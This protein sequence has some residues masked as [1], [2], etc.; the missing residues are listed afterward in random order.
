MFIYISIYI[1]FLIGSLS[2]KTS[3]GGN[4]EHYAPTPTQT[5]RTPHTQRIPHTTRYHRYVSLNCCS[6]RYAGLGGGGWGGGLLSL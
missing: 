2:H 1:A 3:S 6:G 5:Q 4:G